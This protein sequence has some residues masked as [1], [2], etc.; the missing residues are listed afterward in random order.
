MKRP[1]F[2]LVHL[3]RLVSL[4]AVLAIALAGASCKPKK[5]QGNP[6][7][8]RFINRG[9]VITLDINQMSYLQDFRVTYALREGL[10]T[11]DPTQ[12]FKPLPALCVEDS[13]SPDK[14]TWTFK[15]RRD[16][17]WTNGDPVTAQDFI[18]SWKLML[19]SPGEY[20]SLFYYIENAREY[21][22]AY[23]ESKAFDVSTVGFKAVDD[24]TIEVR[25]K[26]PVPFL[27]DLMAFPPFYPRHAGSMAKFAQKDEKGRVSYSAEYTRPENVVTNGPFKLVAWEPG[28]KIRMERNPGYRAA[29]DVKLTAVE[30]VVNNDPQSAFVQ[31]DQGKV[32]WLADVA[33]DIAFE[34]KQAGRPDIH[35]GNAFGTA[36]LTVNCAE[37]V[38]ELNDARNPL[39][40][41]RV[42]QALAMAINRDYVVNNITRMGEKPAMSYVPPGFFDGWVSKPAPG[43]DLDGAKK[44]LADAGFAG[45]KGMPTL[46]IAYNSDSPVRKQLAEYLAFEWRDKLGVP[47]DLRALE[48]KTYRNYVTTKSY[49]LAL[50][51]WYGDYMDPS[52]FTDKYRRDSQNNDS[53]WGPDSYEKLLDAAERE[54]DEK[55]RTDL[56]VQAEA[57][58]N[59][60]L[61]II[62]IYYYVNYTMYRDHVSGTLTNPKN[63]IVWKEI[64]VTR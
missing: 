1:S 35:V 60:E 12:N 55:K 14:K 62:P 15:L 31:Y 54:P 5:S 32:D 38:P 29:A 9:D 36:F 42:R 47:V 57:M 20:T 61:P 50:V 6:G 13:Q 23:R 37:K 22:V 24:Y 33:P 7:E 34:V 18:F 56:L 28:V 19:E 63:L 25:L 10:Y 64:S 51:A 43:Y 58:L 16:A 49:T 48:L 27:R 53:N 4:A 45:G 17:K 40:D 8:F 44:L 2:R 41:Q 59:T 26:N 46:S 52:T 39:A 30:M 11:Y 3:A 21:E